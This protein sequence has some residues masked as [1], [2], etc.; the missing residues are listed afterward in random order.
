MLKISFSLGVWS[1]AL[2]LERNK[3]VCYLSNLPTLGSMGQSDTSLQAA[4][5]LG[6]KTP[7]QTECSVWEVKG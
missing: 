1:A 6:V 4:L 3:L 5:P 2:H 7:L